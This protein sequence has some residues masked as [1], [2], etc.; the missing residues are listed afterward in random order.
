MLQRL[1]QQGS[2]FEQ[3]VSS[4]AGALEGIGVAMQ[5][6]REIER[7]QRES[8]RQQAQQRAE[9]LRQQ[10]QALVRPGAT[11][12]ELQQAAALLPQYR[13]ALRT[14]FGIE[15]MGPAVVGS[16]IMGPAPKMPMTQ[17]PQPRL[18]RMPE[19]MVAPRLPR[20]PEGPVFERQPM[21]PGA[22]PM[23]PRVPQRMEIGRDFTGAGTMA[24]LRAGFMLPQPKRNL[25]EVSGAL[26][27]P[28]A[29]TWVT[30]PAAM[31]PELRRQLQEERLKYEQEIAQARI[32]AAAA[33][34]AA[35]GGREREPR[36]TWITMPDGSRQRVRDREGLVSAANAYTG[37][38]EDPVTGEPVP[39]F[40]PR[41][42]K[43]AGTPAAPPPSRRPAQ[44]DLTPAQQGQVDKRAD[45]I[46]LKLFPEA[47]GTKQGLDILL[48][49]KPEAKAQYDAILEAETARARR[50]V[51]P[52]KG[53]KPA[54]AP[55]ESP[56]Q[57]LSRLE[58]ED[59]QRREAAR[60]RK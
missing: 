44:T 1:R 58:E 49:T 15:S 26:Y 32:E 9:V 7:Q 38:V 4:G 23:Q 28:D 10:S 48:A 2:P 36:Y 34:G 41:T 5:R 20:T 14:G 30:S 8:A 24:G 54:A 39:V 25:I 3:F 55:Q 59:R 11:N 43:P 12:A 19:G 51:I 27:D 47:G 53:G 40:I 46:A 6:Q 13:E 45:N 37:F 29:G 16:P 60:K 57:K 31:T 21:G 22:E 35:G 52:S 17:P 56:L 42:Q 18:A 50:A 33:R